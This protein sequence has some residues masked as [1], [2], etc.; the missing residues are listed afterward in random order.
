MIVNNFNNICEDN[1]DNK[2]KLKRVIT[3]KTRPDTDTLNNLVNGNLGYNNLNSILKNVDKDRIV[4]YIKVTKHETAK[5]D[6]NIIKEITSNDN[7]K[8]ERKMSLN[9]NNKNNNK[10]IDLYFLP[11]RVDRFGTP[12]SHNGKQKVTFIDRITKK[13]FVEVIKVESFKE[14]NKMEE[15]SNT[16]KNNCCLIS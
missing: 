1:K 14:Y 5:I 3:E 8:N 16:R 12:I 9:I 10:N 6:D 2:I 7:S 4:Q 13:N 11:K 15:V